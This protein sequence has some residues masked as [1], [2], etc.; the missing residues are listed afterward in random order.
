MLASV[1]GAPLPS[2]AAGAWL[3]RTRIASL[4][5]ALALAG[6]IVSDVLAAG[7]WRKHPLVTSLLASLLVV[8]ISAGAIN[9]WLANRERRRWALLAQYALLELVRMA[10]ATWTGLL[11]LMGLFDRERHP[12]EALKAGAEV[13]RDRSRLLA[14]VAGV[15]EDPARREALHQ[16]LRRI[17]EGSD[18]LLGRWAGVMLSAA[19]YAETINRHVELYARVSWVTAVLEHF[20]PLEEDPRRR[21]LAGSSPAV[22]FIGQL[23]DRWLSDAL[24]SIVQVA[25]ELDRT[26]LELSF[27]IVSPDWWAQRTSDLSSSS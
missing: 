10:R 13:I 1:S 26:S 3:R 17:A 20:E 23:D 18:V 6:A 9:E 14:S 8:V 19:P 22:A 24:A 27:R 4:V 16:A 25:E 21:R 5:A 15:L 2:Y 11:E 12:A 7:F